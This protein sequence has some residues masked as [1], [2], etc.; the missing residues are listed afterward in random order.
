MFKQVNYLGFEG[1]PELRAKAEQSTGVLA[2]EVH[3]W[4]DDVEVRWE[5]SNGREKGLDLTLSLAL[6]NGV[7]DS[8][9]GT[10]ASR[11]LDRPFRLANRCNQIWRDLLGKVIRQLDDRVQESLAGLEAVEA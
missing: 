9:T 1:Q 11:D 4:R 8:R 3:T 5:P 2:G 7:T 10:I 6:A